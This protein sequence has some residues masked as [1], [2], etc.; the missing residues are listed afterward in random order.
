MESESVKYLIRKDHNFKLL[1]NLVGELSYRLDNDY[2]GFIV[3]TIIGQMLSNKVA[4][5]LTER[6]ENICNSGK[7]DIES[8]KKL[9]FKKLLSIG[10]SRSKTQC[11]IDFTDYYTKNKYT[12]KKLS[13]LSDDEIIK[14]ITAIKGLGIW[15]A[16]MFL[17]FVLGRENILPLEDSAYMQAFIWYNGISSLPSKS[18]IKDLSTQ[19]APYN[20]IVA[21]Y[22]YRALDNGLT[23]KPFL[24]YKISTK[25]GCIKK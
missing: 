14:E 16:K 6:L 17:L 24:S 22:L 15:S 4:D 9:S 19:W 21:R 3:K 8:I 12:H 2:Y 18:E 23:K 1:Y 7:V 11:I 5:I 13:L 20:S 25:K 10:I